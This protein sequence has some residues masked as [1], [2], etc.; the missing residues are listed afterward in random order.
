MLSLCGGWQGCK[1]DLP[2]IVREALETN[3]NGQDTCIDVERKK[4]GRPHF[5]TNSFSNHHLESY[6]LPYFTL[7]G[8]SATD[9]HTPKI[10][11][12]VR[13]CIFLIIL[14]FL[15]FA[16]SLSLA[17]WWSVSRNDVSG[18]FTIGSYIVAVVALPIGIASYQHS[19]SGCQCWQARSVSNET[20]ELMVLTTSTPD[21]P[22]EPG[23]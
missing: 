17:M 4:R 15:A 21:A 20:V 19:R 13:P 7:L 2:N 1:S 3:C 18:G 6:S 9:D 8:R 14:A 12:A 16:I 22:S 5:A 11:F 10:A 23:R